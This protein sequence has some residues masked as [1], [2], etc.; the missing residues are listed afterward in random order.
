MLHVACSRCVTDH[1]F[2]ANVLLFT[3]GS[4]CRRVLQDAITR[5]GDDKSAFRESAAAVLRM[6]RSRAPYLARLP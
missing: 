1:V 3:Q 6:C 2:R 4:G 5:D